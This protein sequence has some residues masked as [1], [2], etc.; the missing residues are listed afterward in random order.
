MEPEQYA[1]MA[2][3]ERDHWWYRGQRRL[4]AALLDAQL[5]AGEDRR[6]LDAGCGTGGTSVWLRRYGAV[7]GVD[8][9][10]EAAPFWRER[11]LAAAAR[12][13]V[14]ALPFRDGCF[15]VV[16]CLDVLYH[17]QVAD[18]DAV[19]AEFWRVLRPGG[20]LLLRVPA[21]DWLQGGH[22]AAVHT[23]RRYTRG[24]VVA[25]VQTAGFEVIRSTYGNGVLLPLA[26]AKRVSERWLGASQAEM[27]LPP[28]LLNAAFTATMGLE[29]RVVLHWAL[30]AGLS[31]LVLGRKAAHASV[32]GQTR[33]WRVGVVATMDDGEAGSAADRAVDRVRVDAPAAAAAARQDALL[34]PT[35][36]R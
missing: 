7:V 27:S 22:D 34:P 24:E 18:E 11:G 25:A 36:A 14:A 2:G 21:Y 35:R 19:L 10:G 32:A 12:G 4:V 26:V 29:A 17:R 8:L 15:D 16:T 9:A 20:L 5:S 30:P 13:S 6:I 33:A 1:L 23:R 31:V 28:G 3:V